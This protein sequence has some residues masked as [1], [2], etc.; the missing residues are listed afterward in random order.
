[1][2][3]SLQ[4]YIDK[5]IKKI[6]NNPSFLKSEIKDILFDF[7]E[8]KITKEI[9]SVF[10]DTQKHFL[11]IKI[12]NPI[13]AQEIKNKEGSILELINKKTSKDFINKIIIKF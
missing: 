6:K 5:K 11:I 3:R 8:E 1:M 12:S 10:F 2:F 4:F 13:F 7:L 9:K